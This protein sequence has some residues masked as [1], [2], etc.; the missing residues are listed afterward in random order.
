MS[1]STTSK[2]VVV[3]GAGPGG[4]AGAFRAADLG[5]SVTLVDPAANPGGVC[6]YRGCIPSKSLLHVAKLLNETKE[7]EAWGISFGEPKVDIDKLRAWKDGVI[8][9]LT[10]GLGGLSKARK[11]NYVRG[12]AKFLSGQSI[13]ITKE[14]G[15]TETVNFDFAILATGS[16]PTTIPAFDMSSDR[17]MD[18]TKALDLDHIP[19]RTVVGF[20]HTLAVFQP[21]LVGGRSVESRVMGG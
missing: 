1:E 11:I 17:I 4:Y 14:D 18:S 2:H 7:A 20:C 6:L 12:T 3:I 10:G 16:R 15:S 9:K 8:S 21:G 5:M 13:E 19:K